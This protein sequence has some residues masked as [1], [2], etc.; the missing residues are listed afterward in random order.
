MLIPLS[1]GAGKTTLLD[2]LAQ[3][4]DEGELHGEVLVNGQPLPLSF[5]RTT[6]FC[7]QVDVHLPQAT[8]REALEFR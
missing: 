2:C 3:R 4:K 5:Q 6:G 8:V 7:E 1:T